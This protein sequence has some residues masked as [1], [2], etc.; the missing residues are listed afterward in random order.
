MMFLWSEMQESKR[1]RGNP[2]MQCRISLALATLLAVLLQASLAASAMQ[3]RPVFGATVARV[4]VDVIVTDD[5]GRFVLDLRP[6]DFV[7]YE[8]EIEQ[9]ILGVQLVDLQGGSVATLTDAS[10]A[11]DLSGGA[12]EAPVPGEATTPLAPSMA[13]E[14][15]AVIY[16]VD[17][18]GLDRRHKD[19][20]AAAWAKHLDQTES[21]STPRAV[22]MIDEVGR[23]RELAPLSRDIHRL[24]RAVAEVHAA[25][26]TRFGIQAELSRTADN[27]M[28]LDRS[29]MAVYD[30]ATMNELTVIE[31]EARGRAI[32]T[33][34]LL[35]QFC[36]ALSVRSGRTAL[37][38]VS[39]EIQIT[40]A[41]PGRAL[42]AAYVDSKVLPQGDSPGEGAQDTMRRPGSEHYPYMTPSAQ[43]LERRRRL[44]NAANSANV[45]IYTVD[46]LPLRE[47]R[48]IAFDTTVY[49]STVRDLLD[50][51]PVQSSLE[52]LKDALFEVAVETGGQAYIGATELD[53][54]LASIDLDASRFYLLSYAPPEPHGDGLFHS[55]GVEVRRPGLTVRARRGYLDLS[56]DERKSLAVNAALAVPGAVSG[57][58][59]RA[60]SFRKWSSAGDPVVLLVV[61]PEG[62]PAELRSFSTSAEGVSHLFHAVALDENGLVFDEVHQQMRPLAAKIAGESALQRA[63]VYIHEWSI[64]P[65]DFEIR[66]AL[67]DS[68]SGE[69][70]ATHIQV[71]V[72]EASGDWSTSDLMIVVTEN[73]QT[74]QPLLVPIVAANETVLAYVEVFGGKNPILSGDILSQDGN[75]RLAV[76]PDLPMGRDRV[77][78]HRAAHRIRGMPPGEYVLQ[79]RV[80]DPGV[81]EEAMLKT[82]LVVLPAFRRN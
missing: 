51:V 25:P 6:E 15:G 42:T 75:R 20:F 82:P 35:T 65:G 33:F 13:S 38:W 53:R 66:I 41:G 70:G 47:L 30:M 1:S 44:H 23:L 55:L 68:L 79:I 9:Q 5:D 3:Q 21:L 18:P 27:L 17:F 80:V 24:R 46:P 63:P 78:I 58:P 16:V 11:G 77:G 37:V 19:R 81:D 67:E 34:D 4:R 14:F 62:N 8:D 56:A 32:S 49:D 36:N 71:E 72:P 10:V 2:M 31:A 7:L 39:S 40:E 57:L 54:A 48:Q 69:I 50:S 28:A 29:G 43:V 45:S 64:P 61:A 26:L 12:A 52:G 74:P 22:Y 60:Q 76:L 73:G 59:F